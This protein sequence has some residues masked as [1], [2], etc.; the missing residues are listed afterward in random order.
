MLAIALLAVGCIRHNQT[1][2]P[3]STPPATGVFSFAL[4]AGSDLYPSEEGLYAEFDEIEFSATIWEKDKVDLAISQFRESFEQQSFRAGFKISSVKDL[5]ISGIPAV[6][7]DYDKPAWNA[8]LKPD[9]EIGKTKVRER[10]RQL[11][12]IFGNESLVLTFWSR[13]AG[14]AIESVASDLLAQART[15][16]PHENRKDQL[17]LRVAGL[18]LASYEQMMETNT[19]PDQLWI[20]VEIVG[21]AG[22]PLQL[23]D[24]ATFKPDAG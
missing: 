13:K 14:A 7:I 11:Y 12:V 23:K 9:G 19:L 8:V 2:K 16:K 3:G 10:T 5:M 18:D 20:S 21:V 24:E 6:V 15:S 22:K 1:T 17:V 4:P